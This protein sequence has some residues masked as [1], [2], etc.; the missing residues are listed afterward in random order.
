MSKISEIID[1]NDLDLNRALAEKT[2]E[3]LNR[4]MVKS[5][6]TK[7]IFLIKLVILM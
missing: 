5:N 1:E 6:W 7:Q 3:Y 2:L 4:A